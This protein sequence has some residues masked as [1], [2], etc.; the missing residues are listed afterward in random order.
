MGTFSTFRRQNVHII[1][2]G[3]GASMQTIS[4]DHKEEFFQKLGEY[5]ADKS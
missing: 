5:Y 1:H 4:A 3:I 2:N